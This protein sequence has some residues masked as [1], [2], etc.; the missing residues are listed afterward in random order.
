MS[1]APDILVSRSMSSAREGGS[2][3]NVHSDDPPGKD[4]GSH[5]ISVTRQPKY[6][7][8]SLA[9]RPRTPERRPKE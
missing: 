7:K 6:S 4:S 3:R 5:G 1:V 9:C 2:V 8:R